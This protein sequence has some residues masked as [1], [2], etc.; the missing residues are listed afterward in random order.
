[1]SRDAEA[2]LSGQI[3]VVTGGTRGIGAAITEALLE[4]AR[5]CARSYAGT[6][7]RAGVRATA[8]RTGAALARTARRRRPAAVERF[9]S[10][11]EPRVRRA[12]RSS[13]T[14][15]AS[16]ATRSS[17]MMSAEDWTPCST[18]TSPARSTWR[19]SPCGA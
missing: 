9:W 8:P 4:A 16:A 7:G 6:T 10:E 3:A 17:G 1:V 5:A 13:S 14:T 18:R 15:P 12:S 19:S 2:G 11:T